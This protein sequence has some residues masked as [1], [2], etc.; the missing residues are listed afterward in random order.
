MSEIIS[1][2][3]FGCGH[4]IKVPAALG[5]KKARCPKCTNTI[6]IPSPSDTTTEDIISDADLPEVAREGDP[7]KDE[8]DAPYSEALPGSTP[9][10]QP[11]VGDSSEIRRKAGSGVR[12]T[13]ATGAYPRVQRSGTQPRYTAP[14]GAAAAGG[15]NAMMIGM[16][17]KGK[18]LGVFGAVAV[19]TNPLRA[20]LVTGE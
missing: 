16:F 5:G 1:A 17:F 14:G 13:G 11:A 20:V 18:V 4:I 8:D 2:R 10:P 3:C 15:N 6:T 19:S 7:F 12:R 9:A